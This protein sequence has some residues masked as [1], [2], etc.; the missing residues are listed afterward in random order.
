MKLTA[1]TDYS[2]RVLIYLAAAPERRATIPEICAAFDLKENHLTKIVHH[3]GKCGWVETTR[4]RGG[5]L[6]LAKPAKDIRIGDV[7]R[8][9]EGQA[10][11]AEC[12]SQ[13]ESTCAIAR[14][15]RLK[16]VLA[17]AVKAFYAVLDR[18]TLADITRNTDE[19]TS[20][21]HFRPPP[22]AATCCSR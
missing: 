11:P 18:Y 8:D 20:I 15:C 6:L 9:T 10:M 1:F 21:L 4:G 5:G 7:V 17:E 16:G 12:F 2:L 22:E 3:L 19:L 13:E 14:C